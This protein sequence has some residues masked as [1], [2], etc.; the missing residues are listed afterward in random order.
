MADESE[1][2]EPCTHETVLRIT[3]LDGTI[4]NECADCTERWVL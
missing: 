4:Y 3:T 1:E 2:Q